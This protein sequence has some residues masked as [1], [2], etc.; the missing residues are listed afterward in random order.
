MTHVLA[1]IRY[2]ALGMC[3]AGGA[4]LALL[5]L[6]YALQALQ[7]QYLPVLHDWR[8]TVAVSDRDLILTGT[9][10][11]RPWPACEYV[12]PQRVVDTETGEHLRITSL[13]PTSG[14]N[15]LGSADGR[16]FGPWQVEDGAGRRLRFYS[17]HEC[18][19]LWSSFSVLGIVD[20]RGKP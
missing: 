19:P 4:L 2:I 20:T 10:K 1:P 15:W 12:P 18:T 3:M 16:T 6:P 13:S 17:E 14:S 11:K 9:V 8:P 7:T 5:V